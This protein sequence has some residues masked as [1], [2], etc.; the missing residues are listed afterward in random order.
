MIIDSNYTLLYNECIR[1]GGFMKIITF[2]FKFYVLLIFS[3]RDNAQYIYHDTVDG[4]QHHSYLASNLFHD[5]CFIALVAFMG[6]NLYKFV[7]HTYRSVLKEI[8]S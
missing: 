3:A 1:P 4:F 6:W 7:K 8:R 2:L 5:F